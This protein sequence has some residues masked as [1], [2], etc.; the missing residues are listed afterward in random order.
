MIALCC[1]RQLLRVEE[2]DFRWSQNG[3]LKLSRSNISMH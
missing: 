3:S 1:G 2:V